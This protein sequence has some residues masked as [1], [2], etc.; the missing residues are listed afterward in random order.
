MDKKVFCRKAEELKSYDELDLPKDYI[1]ILRSS[2]K[3]IGAIIAVVRLLDEHALGFCRFEQIL[4]SEDMIWDL[5]GSRDESD[6]YEVIARIKDCEAMLK[7]LLKKEGYIRYDLGIPNYIVKRYCQGM[8]LM[9]QWIKD[10]E[11]EIWEM[12]EMPGKS[13]DFSVDLEEVGILVNK[14]YETY[15]FSRDDFTEVLEI[16]RSN[17]T[18]G[19]FEIAE[20]DLRNNSNESSF[21][22]YEYSEEESRLLEAAIH[23]IRNRLKEHIIEIIIS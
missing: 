20:F 14:F 2:G 23:N 15:V 17:L 12:T 13:R 5:T 6:F 1:E 16:L 7:R 3:S 4:F 21:V 10:Y 8:S 22:P 19:Q 18:R 11:R 9:R